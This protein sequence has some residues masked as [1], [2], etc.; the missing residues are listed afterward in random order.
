MSNIKR[1]LAAAA[2]TGAALSF[3]GVAQAQE[4][5][6]SKPSSD[7][8]P[9]VNDDRI[10][11]LADGFIDVFNTQTRELLSKVVQ[12]QLAEGS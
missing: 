5:E 12:A 11:P 9:A 10:D 8:V 1:V 4:S 3:C 2:I 7:S 6:P